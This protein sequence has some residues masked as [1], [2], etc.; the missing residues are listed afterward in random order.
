VPSD[1]EV[2]RVVIAIRESMEMGRNPTIGRLLWL[3]YNVYTPERL[4]RIIRRGIRSGRLAGPG[5]GRAWSGYRFVE[6][7]HAE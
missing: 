2:E 4:R 7:P 6:V 5:R 3:T 1:P